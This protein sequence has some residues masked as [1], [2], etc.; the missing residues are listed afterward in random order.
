[1]AELAAASVHLI[2]DEAAWNRLALATPQPDPF[3]ATT[4]WQLAFREAIDPDRRAI[5][6]RSSEGLI[7]FA[8]HTM[9]G[10][11][12]LGPIERQWLFGCNILGPDGPDLFAELVADAEDDAASGPPL[13]LISGLDP[14]GRIHRFLRKKFA[15]WA[16]VHSEVQCAAAL[17]GGLEGFLSRRSAGM[18]RNLRRY[19]KRAVDAGVRFERHAPA[20][21]EEADNV[22]ARMLAVELTSW[23]GLGRCG[24][25]SPRM[26][27]FYATMLR[28]LARTREG[29]VMFA[30][31]D[32]R[33]I[34]FI[35]GGVT[36]GV[37]RGQQFS[38]N[39]EFGA[40][41]IGNLLQFEQVRWLCEEGALRYDLGPLLGPSMGY[42]QHWTDIQMPIDALMIQR[43]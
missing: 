41:S 29:R 35:F 18:R 23:K 38:F 12:V 30:V 24:M 6:R 11:P 31:L 9:S 3:S 32:A 22:F 34:G 14:S 42:K 2:E 37:Y 10:K 43:A 28:R 13:F 21:T 4:H 5:I 20:S 7:H 33:D 15:S 19:M 27:R 36:G 1:M 39:D 26:Q 25:E 40:L 17:E 16:L 8:E